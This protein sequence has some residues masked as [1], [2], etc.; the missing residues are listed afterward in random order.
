M[1]KIAL[2]ISAIALLFPAFTK[3]KAQEL[4]NILFIMADD[5]GY[6]DLSSYGAEKIKTPNIDKLA[7]EGI[8]FTDAHTECST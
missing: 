3:G 7:E 6:A 1:K 4:P 2:T 8:L 5:L